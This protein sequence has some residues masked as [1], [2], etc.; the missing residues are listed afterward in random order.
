MCGEKTHMLGKKVQKREDK[1]NTGARKGQEG[2]GQ[3]GP[4]D[5]EVG[6]GER[7]RLSETASSSQGSARRGWSSRACRPSPPGDTP[8]EPAG[9]VAGPTWAQDRQAQGT[10]TGWA[11][12]ECS[13]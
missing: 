3:P 4:C 12:G 5:R 9:Q 7:A 11:H 2:Q 8:D 6:V 1:S 10:D 13:W